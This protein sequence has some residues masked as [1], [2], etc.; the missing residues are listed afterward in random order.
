MRLGK[1][2]KQEKRPRSNMFASFKKRFQWL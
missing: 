2:K 1:E